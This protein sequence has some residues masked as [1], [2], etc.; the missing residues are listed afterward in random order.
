M[1]K[2]RGLTRELEDMQRKKSELKKQIQ[3]Q[4]ENIDNYEQQI[5]APALEELSRS[6][7]LQICKPL[8]ET[9]PLELRN[10]V[11]FHLCGPEDAYIDFKGTEEPQYPES[12]DSNPHPPPPFTKRDRKPPHWWQADFVGQ[13]FLDEFVQEWYRTSIFNINAFDLDGVKSLLNK[14]PWK[15]NKPPRDLINNIRLHVHTE[16]LG[17]DRDEA[18]IAGIKGKIQE[19][20]NELNAI[21]K[22]VRVSV[23]L[24]HPFSVWMRIQEEMNPVFENRTISAFVPL[25]RHLKHPVQ[26]LVEGVVRFD[27]ITRL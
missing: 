11:Y 7:C 13:Q 27:D 16:L 1:S 15:P 23:N 14:N 26:V 8:V 25:L 22:P 20:I 21:E 24:V 6:Q 5:L 10:I 3:T 19:V 12:T 17:R 4:Q 18:I 2:A 9:L